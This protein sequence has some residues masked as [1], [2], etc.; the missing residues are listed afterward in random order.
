MGSTVG[1]R[2]NGMGDLVARLSRTVEMERERVSR[3]SGPEWGE[4]RVR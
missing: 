3:E 2:V 4:L 1:D